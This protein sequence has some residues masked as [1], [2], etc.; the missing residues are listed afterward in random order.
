MKETTFKG[1]VCLLALFGSLITSCTTIHQFW[2]KMIIKNVY[3][4]F[5]M[6][7]SFLASMGWGL[8]IAVLMDVDFF[9][10]KK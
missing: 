5:W 2:F 8:F 4:D 1:L 3:V 9:G 6:W 7:F 10:V